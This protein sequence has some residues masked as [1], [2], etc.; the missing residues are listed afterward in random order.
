MNIL[1]YNEHSEDQNH[2]TI[3]EQLQTVYTDEMFLEMAHI[4]SKDVDTSPFNPHIYKVD[5]RSNEGDDSPPHIHITHKTDKWEIK[6]YISNGELYQ[7]KQYGNR[8]YSSTFSDIIEL[9]KKWF[10]EQSTLFGMTDKKNFTTALIQW[11][12][13]NPN[14]AVQCNPIW[15]EN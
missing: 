3:D 14:N 4:N 8:K 1:S 15:K 6:V 11:R 9:A 13:L 10:P 2:K 12:V 7:V 5:V